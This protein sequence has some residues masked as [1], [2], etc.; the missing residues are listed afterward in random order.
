MMN[1]NIFKSTISSIF[2]RQLIYPF[3][4]KNITKITRLSTEEN[5]REIVE[6]GNLEIEKSLMEN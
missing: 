3:S 6:R 5:L 2:T 4:N 1:I